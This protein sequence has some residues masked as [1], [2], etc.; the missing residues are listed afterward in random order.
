VEDSEYFHSLFANAIDHDEAR[1]GNDQ[2]TGIAH[3]PRS[4]DI[5]VCDEVLG[6]GMNPLDNPACGSWILAG[7]VVADRL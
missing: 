1:G 4:P 7:D 6:S 2:F 3:S 5:G